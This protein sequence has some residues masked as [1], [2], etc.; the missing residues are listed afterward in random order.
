MTDK[1]LQLNWLSNWK[2]WLRFFFPGL[3][4]ETGSGLS[5][6]AASPQRS[7]LSVSA[8]CL[9]DFSLP[10]SAHSDVSG[11]GVTPHSSTQTKTV[12]ESGIGISCSLLLTLQ[13]SGRAA[14][15][16]CPLSTSV[17]PAPCLLGIRLY[18]IGQH[19]ENNWDL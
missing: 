16:K 13:R 3:K 1:T 7:T 6:G 5:G 12:Q 10:S 9:F 19:E 17:S 4:Q 11:S 14:L 8:G 2:Q 15:G 18:F